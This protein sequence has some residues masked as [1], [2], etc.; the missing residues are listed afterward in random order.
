M[1]MQAFK[2]P[3][4]ALYNHWNT[5]KKLKTGRV[6]FLGLEPTIHVIKKLNQ[7]RETI[8]LNLPTQ[9][10]HP[11]AAKINPVQHSLY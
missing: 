4:F 10:G 6:P 5:Q 2:N 1:P 3:L 7:P 9:R 8:P 11:D